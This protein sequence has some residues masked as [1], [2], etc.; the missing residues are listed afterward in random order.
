[1]ERVPVNVFA[2]SSVAFPNL[3]PFPN[4]F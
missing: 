1:M 2:N 3:P 4:T